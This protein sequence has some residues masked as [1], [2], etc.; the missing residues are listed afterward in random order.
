MSHLYF[1][2]RAQEFLDNEGFLDW[3]SWGFQE[4]S[5][6]SLAGLSCSP[7]RVRVERNLRCYSPSNFNFQSEIF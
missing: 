3:E 6:F 7:G 2:K 5:T 4:I 1:S